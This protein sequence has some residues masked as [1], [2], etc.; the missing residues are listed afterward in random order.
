MNFFDDL[1]KD[2]DHVLMTSLHSDNVGSSPRKIEVDDFQTRASTNRAVGDY[3]AA[4]FHDNHKKNKKQSEER[5]PISVEKATTK[6]SQLDDDDDI[7]IVEVNEVI[8]K[9]SKGS[10]S[11]KPSKLAFEPSPSL[12]IPKSTTRPKKVK[13]FDDEFDSLDS[14]SV[15]DT[16]ED[17]VIKALY[18]EMRNRNQRIA[19]TIIQ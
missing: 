11:T 4:S 14:S 1:E 18:S 5:E 3:T 17:I 8:S 15:C 9:I 2:M 10:T 6:S 12:T 7:C 19:S 16:D 13:E